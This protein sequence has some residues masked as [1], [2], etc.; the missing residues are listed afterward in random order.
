MDTS[1]PPPLDI[2]PEIGLDR[3]ATAERFLIR[4]EHANLW[5]EGQGDALVV[6][7]DDLATIDEGWPRGPV[8][9]DFST[10]V[11]SDKPVLLDF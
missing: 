5:F 6:S 2:P 9:A 10:P 1:D 3:A 8:P 11:S 4:G 7:F